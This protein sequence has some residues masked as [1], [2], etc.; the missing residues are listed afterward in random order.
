MTTAT[1]KVAEIAQLFD[2]LVRIDKERTEINAEW[3]TTRRRIAKHLVLGESYQ[4]ATG[5]G[6]KLQEGNLQFNPM[7]AIGVLVEAD[8]A[9]GTDWLK[10][11]MRT[12]PDKDAARKWLPTSLYE[13]CC[14]RK[15]PYLR[16]FG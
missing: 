13:A 7:K 15:E 3:E 8:A 1:G 11:V 12:M 14:D 2:E 16:R 4:D 6:I 5:L 9:E 10:R